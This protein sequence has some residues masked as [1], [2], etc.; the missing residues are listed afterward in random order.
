MGTITN[1]GWFRFIAPMVLGWSSSGVIG[2]LVL[3]SL[4]ARPWDAERDIG[5]F[6]FYFLFS[7]AVS[8][9]CLMIDFAI[10]NLLGRPKLGS[11][12]LLAILACL[13]GTSILSLFLDSSGE[14]TLL[15]LF[16]SAYA[17]LVIPV[18]LGLRLVFEITFTKPEL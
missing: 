12:L 14:Y 17:V 8:L 15:L 11:F 9:V 16:I 1:T 18:G 7:I 10:G 3:G 6:T 13:V 5:I 4:I 2:G